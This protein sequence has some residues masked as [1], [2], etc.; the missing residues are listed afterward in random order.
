VSELDLLPLPAI[1]LSSDNNDRL[2]ITYS[3]LQ[4]GVVTKTSTWW[5]RQY[6][7]KRKTSIWL[8]ENGYRW[9]LQHERFFVCLD[10]NEGCTFI[11]ISFD[12]NWLYQLQ[13]KLHR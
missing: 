4:D 3:Y 5:Q 1:I 11:E 10:D 9:K 6:R 8:D 2:E 12:G 7:Y 13:T